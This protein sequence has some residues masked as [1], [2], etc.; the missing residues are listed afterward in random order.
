MQFHIVTAFPDIV[1]GSLGVSI[2]KRAIDNGYIKVN[3]VP[4]RNFADGKH[5]QL[6]D[7]PYGGG[8]G[9]VL[10]P[11][12]IF[13]AFE[14]LKIDRKDTK[15]RL[16]YMSPQGAALTQEKLKELAALNTIVVLCGRYKGVDQRV[17][18][19]W[20]D[21]EI[22]IGDYVLSGGEIPSL[23]LVDGV[24]RLVPGVLGNAESAASD[25]FHSSLL[26]YPAYTRPANW[27]GLPVPEVLLNGNH[28]K[29]EEWRLNKSL[30]KTEL[31]RND[32]YMKYLDNI[33]ENKNE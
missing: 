16:V 11:E 27:Q 31:C 24:S 6:D 23:V 3:V 14:S 29:I 13:R 30:Q 8:P 17:I 15:T 22:S 2:L 32:L 19:N 12:P 10:K 20:I 28:K 25:S 5:L 1:E 18:D 9:M 4:L 21:E 26:D 7:Y 33:E